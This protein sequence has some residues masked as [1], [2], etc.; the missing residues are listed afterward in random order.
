MRKEINLIIE[1]EGEVY[2]KDLIKP[3]VDIIQ[4]V[5][6]GS[7]TITI[8]PKEKEKISAGEIDEILPKSNYVVHIER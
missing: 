7:P 8:T 4:S 6:G 2:L 5:V 1:C 3:I